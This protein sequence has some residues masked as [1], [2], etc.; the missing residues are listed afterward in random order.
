MKRQPLS[1]A[2]GLMIALAGI[3]AGAQQPADVLQA[4]GLV[5]SGRFFVLPDEEQI[6]QGLIHM[7][8]VMRLMDG[9]YAA[10]KA[11]LQNE[12]EFQW[13]GDY[14]IQMQ[15]KSNDVRVQFNNMPARN[16][17]ERL[18]KQEAAQVLAAYAAEIRGAN[19]QLE[20]RRKRL[21]GDAGKQRAENQAKDAC[22]TFLAAKADL[23]PEYERLMGR[24]LELK[25]DDAVQNALKVYNSKAQAHLKLGPSDDLTRKVKL[26]LDYE[27]TYSPET[28]PQLK[29]LT[30][31]QKLD[32]KKKLK[33]P[34][35]SAADDT[36]A[37]K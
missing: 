2:L 18:Q 4:H 14:K 8:P 23:W 19:T 6:S 31:V 30:R 21:V 12:Y 10:W 22:R 25:N 24:Y 20:L 36:M 3:P 37:G 32:R 15:A 1:L 29:K 16:P 7:Q 11:I 34:S 35:S 28:A 27:R 5:K 33:K 9:K 26:V 17:M 13:W